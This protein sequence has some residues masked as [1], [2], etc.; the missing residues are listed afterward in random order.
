VMGFGNAD[1]RVWYRPSAELD[2][3]L[4]C[5]VKTKQQNRVPTA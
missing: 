1:W 2:L 5:Y 4:K 3:K